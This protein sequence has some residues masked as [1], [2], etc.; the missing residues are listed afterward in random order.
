VS[1]FFLFVIQRICCCHW[2]CLVKVLVV[3]L[4]AIIHFGAWRYT[5]ISVIHCHR[6]KYF[7]ITPT[8]WRGVLDTFNGIRIGVN[9]LQ[10]GLIDGDM[11]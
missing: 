3:F 5:L 8:A 6:H 4:N 9:V 2:V 1:I 7:H 11:S 10:M